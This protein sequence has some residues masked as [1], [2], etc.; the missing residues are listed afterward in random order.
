MKRLVVAALLSSAAPA[1]LVQP[2]QAQTSSETAGAQ[3]ASAPAGDAPQRDAATVA[4]QGA[5]PTSGQP[6]EQAREGTT[7]YRPDFFTASRPNTASE[8]IGRLPGFQLDTG[9][10]ARGFAGTSGNVLI[11]G[12]HPASK[13]DNLSDILARIPASQ[14]ERI[15]V[16][17]GG[18]PGIDMQGRSVVANVVRR[19]GN[20]SQQVL[21]VSTHWFLQS[22]DQLP[23]ARYELTRTIGPR[24]L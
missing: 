12:K 19:A 14:V 15:E 4:T 1:L 10:S 20:A 3:S 11:D 6:D 5:T 18:A 9:S 8:M 23:S 16:I 7:V 2:A 13:S 24:T 21:S 22:G 17:R